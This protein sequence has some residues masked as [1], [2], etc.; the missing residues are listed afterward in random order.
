MKVYAVVTQAEYEGYNIMSVY[1]TKEAA[2][3]HTK[4]LHDPKWMPYS[5]TEVPYN[6]DGCYVMELE[7]LD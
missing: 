6:Q 2:V 7:V 3:K 5:E 1:S 4:A